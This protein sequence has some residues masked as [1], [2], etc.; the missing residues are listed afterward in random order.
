MHPSWG[1]RRAVGALR[2]GEAERLPAG[3]LTRTAARDPLRLRGALG[4]GAPA[5]AGLKPGPRPPPRPSPAP[6]A[7][8]AGLQAASG[9]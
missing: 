2:L 7:P 5:G 1:S 8:R 9:Q 3:S 4:L 6:A